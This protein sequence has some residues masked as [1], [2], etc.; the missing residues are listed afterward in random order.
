M[1]AGGFPS[2]RRAT[3][4]TFSC[5]FV[6]VKSCDLHGRSGDVTHRESC[7]CVRRTST[8]LYSTH[9]I[10]GNATNVVARTSVRGHVLGRFLDEFGDFVRSRNVERNINIITHLLT[11]SKLP[12][13]RRLEQMCLQLVNGN[14]WCYMITQRLQSRHGQVKNSGVP[15]QQQRISPCDGVT[16]Q[17]SFG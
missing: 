3:L 8:A 9:E 2:P 12:I 17:Y 14:A 13:R 4:P 6:A 7:C 15:I 5:L 16:L 11:L 1:S 10:L